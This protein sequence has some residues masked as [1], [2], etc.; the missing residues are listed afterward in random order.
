M[1][2]K[3]SFYLNIALSFHRNIACENCSSDEG[4]N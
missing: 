2:K 1:K 4:H 3:I